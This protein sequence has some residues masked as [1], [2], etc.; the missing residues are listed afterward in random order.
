M[1]K[2][3]L[4]PHQLTTEQMDAQAGTIVDFFQLGLVLSKVTQHPFY[5]RENS[6]VR[7]CMP[8]NDTHGQET[9]TRPTGITP[10]TCCYVIHHI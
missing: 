2:A 1:D 8:M 6:T 4:R 3:Q 5:Q 7:L 10:H 9:N